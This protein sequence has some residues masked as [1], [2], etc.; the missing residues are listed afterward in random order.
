MEK[1]LQEGYVLYATN[2]KSTDLMNSKIENDFDYFQKTA[3]FSPTVCY[4]GSISQNDLGCELQ[5]KGVVEVDLSAMT[6]LDSLGGQRLCRSVQ[7]WLT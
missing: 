4:N 2:G 5:A 1:D 3:A 6:W 7:Q